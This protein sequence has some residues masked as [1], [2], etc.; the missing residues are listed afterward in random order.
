ML[1]LLLA[2]FA[3]RPAVV[4]VR[5]EGDTA[6]VD[7]DAAGRSLDIVSEDGVAAAPE[8]AR[9]VVVRVRRADGSFEPVDAMGVAPPALWEHGERER[10]A[11]AQA[12]GQGGA[13]A[14]KRIV[15]SAGHGWIWFPDRE[16]WDTQRGTV[17]SL[18]EDFH[19]NQI[20]IQHLAP[21]L[22]RAG[23][24]VVTVRE[25]TYAAGERSLG[26]AAGGAW[27]VTAPAFDE[28]A[29]YFKSAASLGM[30]AF[31]IEHAGGISDVSADLEF[32]AGLWRYLGRFWFDPAGGR[33]SGGPPGAELRLAGGRGTAVF[34][35]S[36]P[37]GKP[38]WQEGAP[39]YLQ[40]L[41]VPFDVVNPY[42]VYVE[43][44]A[45]LSRPSYA[46]WSGADA[47]LSVHTNAAGSPDVGSGTDTFSYDT[48]PSR[49]PPG[50]LELR[51]A[52]QEALIAAARAWL[53]E[54]KDRGEKS[55]N[56]GELRLLTETPQGYRGIPGVLV[57]LA[58]HDT[59]Y[60]DNLFLREEQFR[61]D[62]ARG[63]HRGL[64]SLL[65]PGTPL[66]PRPPAAVR[67]WQLAT[68]RLRVEWRAA[69]E[70]SG[71]RVYLST[72]GYAFDPDAR[73]TAE[74]SVE[75]EGLAPCATWYLRVNAVNASGESVDGPVLSV[76]TRPPG[77]PA[78]LFVNAIHRGVRLWN[79]PVAP[80]EY[81]PLYEPGLRAARAFWD[82]ATSDAIAAGVVPADAYAASFWMFAEDSTRDG[83]FGAALRAWLSDALS[84]GAG[85]AVSGAE[86]GWDLW[87]KG[88]AETQAWYGA[89]LGASYLRDAAGSQRVRG[90]P[91]GAFAGL[92]ARF[93]EGAPY[94]VEY[95]D[96]LSAQPGARAEAYYGDSGTEAAAVSVG[97]VVY[98]GF[99]LETVAGPAR[100]RFVAGAAEIALGGAQ[101]E[102]QCTIAPP[103]DGGTDAATD[104]PTVTDAATDTGA[105]A[106][107][108]AGSATDAGAD[109]GSG[110]DAPGGC[111]CGGA[112]SPWLLVFL[113][114]RGRKRAR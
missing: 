93:G 106:A 101:P 44:S 98:F 15:L 34:G 7:M 111:G 97:R 76:R 6:V 83:T 18:R 28:Y 104:S 49:L 4:A 95:P 99:P 17:Y 73:E 65:A 92:D 27:D 26:V 12:A 80:R 33:V 112:R 96:V 88:T 50:T 85:A 114:V 74:T 1:A 40:D 41:G 51:R 2:S 23:A 25:R 63:L 5:V 64:Q 56:F 22:E 81:A 61:R 68:G 100:D 107:P 16:V 21:M 3:A 42:G 69:A 110:G 71:Y 20:V 48:D 36:G 58:F 94:F 31:R 9:R 103:T 47:Y 105:D 77:A 109:A 102:P 53:P 46:V 35:A 14:G 89:T 113:L 37:S 10:R 86:V 87:E 59:R 79:E 67:A 62:M 54:W 60:P 38:R 45:F 39:P 11:R 78:M 57:E 13:L 82:A 55:A 75:Y 30:A 32:D 43:A 8:S 29:V 90:S 108:D 66:P 84:R 19:T 72:D 70:A 52:V 91:S 24:D